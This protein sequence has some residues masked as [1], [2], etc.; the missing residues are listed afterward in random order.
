M[1]ESKSEE[2][3]R[4]LLKVLGLAG[5]WDIL[6]FL[7]ENGTGTY[8]DLSQSINTH[9]LNMRLNALIEYNMIVHHRVRNPKREWY[10]ITEK[11][12]EIFGLLLK[13]LEVKD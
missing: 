8:L 7:F 1:D 2:E 5:T 13:I 9:T 12:K 10:E 3:E 6:H 11:G 4:Q